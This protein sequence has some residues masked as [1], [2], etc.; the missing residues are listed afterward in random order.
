MVFVVYSY[1]PDGNFDSNLTES[2]KA[3]LELCESLQA[4]G[5]KAEIREFGF[6]E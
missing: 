2:K 4:K 1:L 3:A 6:L 5:V